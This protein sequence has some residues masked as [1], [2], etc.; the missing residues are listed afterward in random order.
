VRNNTVTADKIYKEVYR[1]LSDGFYDAITIK[2]PKSTAN[3]L[4]TSDFHKK[5][6]TKF[7]C[8]IAFQIDYSLKHGSYEVIKEKSPASSN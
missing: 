3:L 8:N 7:K 4:E 1:I 5:L 2:V 6:Q